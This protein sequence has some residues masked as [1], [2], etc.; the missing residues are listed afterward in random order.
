M[1]NK[2]NTPAHILLASALMLPMLTS[3]ANAAIVLSVGTDDPNDLVVT[4]T[5]SIVIPVSLPSGTTE[6]PTDNRWGIRLENVFTTAQAK[7]LVLGEATSTMTVPAGVSFNLVPRDS[8]VY[9]YGDST[10]KDLILSWMFLQHSALTP[11]QTGT[12]S[13][14]NYVLKGFL[15]S[16]NMPDT[17]ASSVTVSF[18]ESGRGQGYGSTSVAYSSPIPEPSSALVLG[19]GALAAGLRRRR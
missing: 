18:I 12:V 7:F 13:T 9:F 4:I 10:G 11:G 6:T 17:G 2:R 15:S 1:L 5:E 16:G 14:G 19:L 8:G 3:A